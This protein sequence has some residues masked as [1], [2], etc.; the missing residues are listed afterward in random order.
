MSAAVC[1]HTLTV[2]SSSLVSQ[3]RGGALPNSRL[4]PPFGP[5]EHPFLPPWSFT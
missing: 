5:K 4:I 3:D 1:P 2:V